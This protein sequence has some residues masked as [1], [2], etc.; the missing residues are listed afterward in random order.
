MT[1]APNSAPG[2][3]TNPSIGIEWRSDS[4]ALDWDRQLALLGGHPLQSA[5]WGDARSFV[6]GI[7]N[8]R[9]AA[10]GSDGQIVLMARIET[11][12]MPAAGRVAWIPKGP[13]TAPDESLQQAQRELLNRLRADGYLICIDDPYPERREAASNG[14]QLLPVPHTILIDLTVGKDRLWAGLDSQWRY[15]VRASQRAGVVVSRS[16]EPAAVAE[17]YGLCKRLSLEKGFALPGS[18]ALMRTLCT[19]EHG[20]DADAVLFLAHHIDERIAAG[21]LVM[22][23]GLTAHYMWG[24]TERAFAKQRPGEAV[25]WAV[26]EWCLENRLRIYDLEGIDPQDNP[27]TSLF[28]RKMGGKEVVLPGKQAFPLGVRGALVLRAARWL[29]KL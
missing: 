1:S 20:P 3:R 2:A 17:F 13:A 27:S 18:E 8:Q 12:R 22:R 29:G 24:A 11:R 7:P 5:L 14:R 28:K 9:W 6:D 23:C 25:Q 21:A 19:M 10:V 26:I 16:T 4:P 15:G